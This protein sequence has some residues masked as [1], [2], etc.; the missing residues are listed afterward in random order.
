MKKSEFCRRATIGFI[1]GFVIALL[2]FKKDS[3]AAIFAVFAAISWSCGY[4]LNKLG[5]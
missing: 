1:A 5:K 4:V 3:G 2:F